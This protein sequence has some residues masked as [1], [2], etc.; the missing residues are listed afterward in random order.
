[1]V[2]QAQTP[3]RPPS[4]G[5]SGPDARPAQLWQYGPRGGHDMPEAGSDVQDEQAAN[6]LSCEA[7]SAGSRETAELPESAKP[8]AGH[9]TDFDPPL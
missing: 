2:G 9:L 5:S 3:D 1:M 8:A 4:G 6:R 7:S